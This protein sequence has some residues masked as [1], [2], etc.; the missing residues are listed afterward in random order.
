[1]LIL[2]DDV[3]GRQRG[4]GVRPVQLRHVQEL[5][6]LCGHVRQHGREI[7][8]Q[9]F[10]GVDEFAAHFV[11]ARFHALLLGQFPRFVGIHIFVH[12]VRQGHDFAQ[13]FGVFAVFVIGSD[14]VGFF[15]QPCN[16]RAA[17]NGVQA[18]C[19]FF[20]D[21]AA[22]TAGDVD[23][24]AH[25]IAVYAGDKILQIQIDVFN[26]AVELGGDVIAHPFGVQALFQIGFGGDERAARF[27]HFLAV[28][29]QKAVRENAVWRAVAAELQ[30]GRPEQGVE[31]QDVFADE[32][33]HFGGAVF[34]EK[35]VEI[36]TDFVAQVLETCHVAHGRVQPYIEIFVGFVGDLEAEIG[37]VAAD[38]PVGQFAVFEPFVHFVQGF[39]LQMG[40]AVGFAGR[41]LF[42]IIGAVA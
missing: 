24:F 9:D 7:G 36:Q 10:E 27:G 37:R 22:G 34:A 6:S 33:V 30:H 26:F 5:G 8:R 25:Q 38:I 41:P 4:S 1:M 3:V 15:G 2:V 20:V 12:D 23:V 35:F 39:G 42:Q 32:V 31:I 14:A 19:K 13:G 40:A 28:H 16:Q 21:E 11:Q 29:R 17:R 18:A